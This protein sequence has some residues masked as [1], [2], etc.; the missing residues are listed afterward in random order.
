MKKEITIVI[1]KYKGLAFLSW[2]SRNESNIH[3]DAD[4]IPGLSQWVKYSALP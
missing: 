1:K 3:E 2:L 4:S